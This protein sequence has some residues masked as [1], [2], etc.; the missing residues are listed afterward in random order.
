V[1]NSGK[2]FHHAL[3][4][5]KNTKAK[6]ILTASSYIK[7]KTTFIPDFWVKNINAWIVFPYDLHETYDAFFCQTIRFFKKGN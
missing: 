1:S 5:Y 7:P 3:Y 4:H 2:T 6:K